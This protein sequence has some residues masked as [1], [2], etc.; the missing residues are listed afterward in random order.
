MGDAPLVRARVGIPG[1]EARVVAS[2]VTELIVEVEVAD[3][4]LRLEWDPRGTGR[5]L[6]VGPWEWSE[7]TGL[8]I[9]PAERLTVLDALW[10]LTPHI[11]YRIVLAYEPGAD[12]WVAWRWDRGPDGHVV[13]VADRMELLELRRTAHIP[14]TRTHGPKGEAIATAHLAQARWVYPVQEAIEAAD[15]DRLRERLETTIE[16]DFIRASVKWRL[17]VDDARTATR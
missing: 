7:P 16:A 17:V 15:L 11:G 8:A 4:F 12:A 6:Y 9:T 1:G 3:R 5:E 2:A 14:A 10:A 13:Y